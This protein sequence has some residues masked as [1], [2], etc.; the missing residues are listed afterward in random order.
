MHVCVGIDRAALCSS[1]RQQQ[2]RNKP[3]SPSGTSPPG[4]GSS[5]RSS[6]SRR[7]TYNLDRI[8]IPCARL[9]QLEGVGWGGVCPL[10][11]LL[12]LGETD[13]VFFVPVPAGKVR[14]GSVS[15]T[16]V[17]VNAVVAPPTTART[18]AGTGSVGSS[19]TSA[20]A[21]A[22]AA[23]AAAKRHTCDS[24]SSSSLSA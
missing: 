21:A 10:L 22:V 7:I 16:Q 23:G 11:L 4:S 15:R 9:Q 2:W 3:C 12:L 5:M 6:Q 1:V 8:L 19:D 14:A 24:S 18:P 20:A 13:L 17:K